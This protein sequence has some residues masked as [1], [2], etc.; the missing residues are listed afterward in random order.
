MRVLLTHAHTHIYFLLQLAVHKEHMCNIDQWIAISLWTKTGCMT[1]VIDCFYMDMDQSVI[2]S[3]C[4]ITRDKTKLKW[5]LTGIARGRVV[6]KKMGSSSRREREREVSIGV[7]RSST[8]DIGY[9]SISVVGPCVPRPINLSL[10]LDR[11]RLHFT[12]PNCEAKLSFSA[13][14]SHCPVAFASLFQLAL[15]VSISSLSLSLSS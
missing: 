7:G 2:S 9:T 3:R 11:L 6:N 14:P 10:S 13:S 4:I 8:P 12:R 5:N 1:L 15:L